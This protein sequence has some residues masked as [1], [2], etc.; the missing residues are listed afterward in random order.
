M[1]RYY[2]YHAELYYN[3]A[4]SRDPH[5]IV[6]QRSGVFVVEGDETP[7]RIYGK[8]QKMLTLPEH[9][10]AYSPVQ[11]ADR[12]QSYYIIKEFYRVEG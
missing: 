12:K 10:G 6:G 9:E 1:P 5:P 8:V 3:D 7:D 11:A 4:Q 2:F